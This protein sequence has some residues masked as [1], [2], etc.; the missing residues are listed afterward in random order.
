MDVLIKTTELTI[1]VPANSCRLNRALD[2]ITPFHAPLRNSACPHW[3]PR[4]QMT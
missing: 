2:T 4:G 3:Q 1:T